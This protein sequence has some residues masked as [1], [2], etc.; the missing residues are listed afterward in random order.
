MTGAISG[1]VLSPVLV[2]FT[3]GQHHKLVGHI[4][5]I[6]RVLDTR[7]VQRGDDVITD[8]DHALALEYGRQQIA[9]VDQAAADMDVVG[10]LVERYI[11]TAHRLRYSRSS[12]R[13]MV[14]GLPCP[15][16]AM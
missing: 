4:G 1:I 15:L 13:T 16:S 7:R 8:D 6:Q 12:L 2:G 10:A 3:I 11:Q 14:N 5:G 9:P